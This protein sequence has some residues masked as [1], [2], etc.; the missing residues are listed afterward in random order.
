[1]SSISWGFACYDSCLF[2]P[3]PR[4]WPR[5]AVCIDFQISQKTVCSLQVYLHPN[6][7]YRRRALSGNKMKWDLWSACLARTWIGSANVYVCINDVCVRLY[8]YM[9]KWV[10]MLWESLGESAKV[11]MWYWWMN[12]YMYI[13]V[14]LISGRNLV[15][16]FKCMY[17]PVFMYVCIR[18]QRL[19]L[20]MI[21]C[22]YI[23]GC[24]ST[25]VW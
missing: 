3:W 24:L 19:S 15:C 17:K 2:G 13:S 16:T 1:M 4:K 9:N 25:P 7:T 23:F 5:S 12:A 22:A 14:H 20:K 6:V 18:T 10:V 8:I 21:T 11:C